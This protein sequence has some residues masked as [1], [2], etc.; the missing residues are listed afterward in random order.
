MENLE[1]METP[2]PSPIHSPVTG[3]TALPEIPSLSGSR[4]ASGEASIAVK[5]R[6]EPAEIH[7]EGELNPKRLF[8]SQAFSNLY[9]F[10]VGSDSDD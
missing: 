5:E 9:T 3:E 10:F 2:P 6:V 8:A 7:V 4:I 1:I